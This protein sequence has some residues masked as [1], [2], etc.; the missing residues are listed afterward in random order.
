MSSAK[1]R[2]FCNPGAYD[3][4]N[5]EEHVTKGQRAKPEQRPGAEV[6]SRELAGT[7]EVTTGVSTGCGLAVGLEVG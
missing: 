3:I 7:A 6:R 2:P 1:F 5:R 4:A